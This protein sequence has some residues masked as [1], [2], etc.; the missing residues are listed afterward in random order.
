MKCKDPLDATTFSLAPLLPKDIFPAELTSAS[1][2][3]PI[4]LPTYGPK[5]TYILGCASYIN[6][7]GNV[8]II[9]LFACF[10]IRVYIGAFFKSVHTYLLYFSMVNSVSQ[11]GHYIIYFTDV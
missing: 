7:D 8:N 11:Y 1:D 5:C 6:V 10:H 3:L 2:P 9:L 4:H